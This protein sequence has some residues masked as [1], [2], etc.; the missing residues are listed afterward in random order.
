[1]SDKAYYI[2]EIKVF[3][4][5]KR[6]ISRSTN[7]GERKIEFLQNESSIINN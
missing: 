5:P 4:D 1:M 6:R 7:S 2:C 3:S